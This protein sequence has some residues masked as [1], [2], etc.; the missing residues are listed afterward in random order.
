MISPI[1][2]MLQS[3][4]MKI[5]KSKQ[6][7]NPFGG[8]NFVFETLDELGIDKILETDLPTLSPQC[9]YQWKDLLYSFWSIY[10]CGGTHIED[11]DRN[12]KHHLK[13]NPF[14]QV[15]SPDRIIDRFKSLSVTDDYLETDRGKHT[16]QFNTHKLLNSLLLKIT[17]H[18]NLAESNNQICDYD[19]T[20]LHTNKADSE[21]TYL[22]DFGY[23]P[24]IAFI[25]NHVAFIENRN[26]KSDAQTL[27]DKTLENMFAS[28]KEQGIKINQFRAD[29]ASYLLLVLRMLEK[30]VDKFYIRARRSANLGKAI[31]AIED[32]TEI[33]LKG[34]K[35]Y[36]AAIEYTPFKGATA[37][38]H[39][40]KQKDLST[41]R[42][43]VTK[44]ARKDGQIDIFTGDAYLY[45]MIITND[46]EMT[47]DEVVI[48]YN[49]RGKTEREFDTLK[50]DFGWKGLAF[51]KLA[52]NTVFLTFT[53]ICKNLYQ[54]IIES[55]SK[56]FK[57]LKSTFQLKK[58]IF[59]FISLPAKWVKHSGQKK[60]RI[61]AELPFRT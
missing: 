54:Y 47:M 5:V 61:Y 43:V 4:G 7:I 37:Q 45:S 49:Q 20:V 14:V 16:H 57:H 38:R 33:E 34:E 17:K 26:G 21:F 8:I 44:Q 53:A 22:K 29:S 3:L 24:G 52:Q 2:V 15:P 23:Q 28:F 41:Y 18:C 42:L 55:Y 32:W 50:N 58:F 9:K 13:N 60:L 10:L 30:E 6:T 59:R 11:I 40:I 25:N 12:L 19:N 36:R 31:A 1:L 39:G 35:A 48:F 27:Q 51:S 46:R 56:K